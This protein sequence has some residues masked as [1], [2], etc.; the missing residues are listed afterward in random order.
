M[1]LYFTKNKKSFTHH[2]LCL[3]FIILF[4]FL[5]VNFKDNQVFADN[6]KYKNNSISEITG[7]RNL[8]ILRSIEQRRIRRNIELQRQRNAELET[9][10]NDL[11]QNI[12]AL[13]RENEE[14]RN[15]L[16][17]NRTNNSV[18]QNNNYQNH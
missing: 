7:R 8:I 14:L 6:K 13:N 10:I 17:N 16:S 18:N 9:E 15:F 11:R 5:I 12:N 3:I 4:F 2:F 1:N